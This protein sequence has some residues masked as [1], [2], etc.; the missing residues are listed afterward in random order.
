[1]F[2]G[3]IHDGYTRNTVIF[4]YQAV[5][6]E[7]IY[8]ELFNYCKQHQSET[9]FFIAIIVFTVERARKS[10]RWFHFTTEAHLGPIKK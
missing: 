5:K 9:F 4:Y 7:I 6:T 3:T 2:T 1:M 10:V 8:F